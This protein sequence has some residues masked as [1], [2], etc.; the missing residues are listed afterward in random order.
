M[1]DP[2]APIQPDQ[3]LDARGLSNVCSDLTPL[4]NKRIRQLSPN[5]VLE[6]LTLNF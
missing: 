4:I 3:S 6:V 1:L 5:Q 2:L